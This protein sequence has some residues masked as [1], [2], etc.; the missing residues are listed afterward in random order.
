MT[1][2]EYMVRFTSQKRIFT[3]SKIDIK[4]NKKIH[5]RQRAVKSLINL[6]TKSAHELE[7]NYFPLIPTNKRKYQDT[8]KS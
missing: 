8:R 6:H 3:T 4:N 7:R 2:T 5:K 1:F